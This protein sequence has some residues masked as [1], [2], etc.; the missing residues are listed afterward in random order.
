MASDKD[1]KTE[2]PSER[3]LS[4]AAEK[5]DIPRSKDM[6][7]SLSLLFSV[8]FF[9]LFIP[10]LSRTLLESIRLYIGRAGELT[11]T[12]STMTMM[13]KNIFFT[14]LKLLMP[15]F[16]LLIAIVFIMEV[17]QAK[18]LKFIPSNIKIKWEKV[19]FWNQILSGLKKIIG[20]VEA[21]FELLKSFV[22]IIIIGII[23]YSSIKDKIPAVLDLSNRTIGDILRLMG[24]LFFK[25]AINIVLFLLAMAVL[26]YFWQR[27]QYTKKL[28]MSKQDL[29]DEFKQSEGDPVVKGRQ[30]KIQFQW[31]MR[32]M[33]AQV[34]QADVVITNPTHYAVALMYEAK[35]MKS[36]RLVA[37]GQDLVAFRI[38]DLAKEHHVPVVEN[39]PVARA[40]FDSVEIDGFIPE[41]LFKPVAEILAYIYKLKGKKAV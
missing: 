41:S 18:G 40:I 2:K 9:A 20:S 21:L 39:P 29:K 24:A 28:K 10:Y 31:A 35:K 34:P 1:N 5:G 27:Y 30:K 3:R 6:V 33:M 12:S 17:I 14:Y 23:A 15:L 16:T 37:K 8:L 22:K 25:L 13:G 38:R 11:L 7:L 32:R 36:P 19:F 4:E 26:D